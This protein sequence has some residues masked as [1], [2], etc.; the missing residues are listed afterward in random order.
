MSEKVIVAVKEGKVRGFKRKTYYSGVEFYTFLG[1]PYGQSTAGSARFK[2]PVKVKPWK[3]ILDATV[4]R[5]G[6]RQYSI[7]KRELLGSEDCLYNNIYTPKLRSSGDGLKAVIVNI[8]PGGRFHGSPDPSYFGAPD[9][10]MHHDVVYVCVGYRLHLLGCLNLHMK[11]CSGNQALKDVILSL[12]WIKDNISSFGG[13]PDNITL[14]GSSSA[15]LLVHF[16]LLSPLAK[17]LYHK[18][19][20]MGTYAF[21][22][23]VATSSE[24]LPTA[25]DVAVRTGYDGELENHKKLLHFYKNLAYDQVPII[26]HEQLIRK[27]IAIDVFPASPFSL[28]PEPGENSPVPVSPEKLIPSTNRVPIIIGFCEKEACMAIAKLRYRKQ[29]M[30]SDF[31]KVIQQNVWGWGAV[32]SKDELKLVQKEVE[33]FYLSGKSIETASDTV[34]CD[35]LTDTALSGVYDSLINVISAD[36]SSPVYAYNFFYD[37]KLDALKARIESRVQTELTG[38]FHGAD[39]NY[40]NY[41]EDHVG[42]SMS[43]I[44]PEDRHIIETLTSLFTTFAKT[45]NP[46]YKRLGVKWKPTTIECPSHL[47]IDQTL[48]VKDELL[49]GERMQFWQNLKNKLN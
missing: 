6:C 31:Y 41:L 42:K 16:T 3:D 18:A 36:P 12:Q 22:P 45:S 34:L 8:H 1:V 2:D 47:I 46:N 32:L 5:G 17:G 25:Y 40:W 13:D 7:W 35:I 38:S 37:G 26:K 29:S 19:I 28:T 39:Y 11:A 23:V 27:N 24:N 49:N 21:S 48:E 43:K 10:I 30:N 4:E 9:Y 14:M 20:L 15:A 44:R 33:M